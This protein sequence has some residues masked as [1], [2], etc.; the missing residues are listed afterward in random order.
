MTRLDVRIATKSD[1]IELHGRAPAYKMRAYSASIDGRVVGMAGIQY[2]NGH[3]I[4]FCDTGYEIKKYKVSLW[5][6]ALKSLELLSDE[7][8]PIYSFADPNEESAH[9]WLERIGFE[10]LEGDEYIWPRHFSQ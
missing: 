7:R 5:K 4:A 6:F 8:R 3:S 1:F 9:R 2:V 10:Q